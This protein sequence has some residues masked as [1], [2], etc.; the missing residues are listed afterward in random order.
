MVCAATEQ[1]AMSIF[2]ATYAP[3]TPKAW[4]PKQQLKKYRSYSDHMS[5]VGRFQVVSCLL[6][7]GNAHWCRTHN[8]PR[9][10]CEC[11]AIK[12]HAR[13]AAAPRWKPHPVHRFW[14]AGDENRP[15]IVTG[16]RPR[17]SMYGWDSCA[18]RFAEERSAWWAHGSFKSPVQR[19]EAAEK[20][21]VKIKM[22]IV[23]LRQVNSEH[24]LST[25]QLKSTTTIVVVFLRCMTTYLRYIWYDKW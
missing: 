4:T 15:V 22:V 21:C 10:S 3:Q 6:P 1:H 11:H 16:S 18:A 13:S 24:Q 2:P 8:G 23:K 20:L 7:R 14:D 25:T 12:V 19:P 17:S 5:A 9:D